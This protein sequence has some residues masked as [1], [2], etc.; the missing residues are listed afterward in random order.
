M[1]LLREYYPPSFPSFPHCSSALRS[2]ILTLS[3]SPRTWNHLE[4]FQGRRKK[5]WGIRRRRCCLW[6]LMLLLHSSVLLLCTR[7]IAPKE[8]ALKMLT[9]SFVIGKQIL[10]FL[11]HSLSLSLCTISCFFFYFIDI[12]CRFF[13]NQTLFGIRFPIIERIK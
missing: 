4:I 7:C 9:T 13:K 11:S 3:R 10:I 12:N 8:Y 1:T 5:T 6:F 2:R